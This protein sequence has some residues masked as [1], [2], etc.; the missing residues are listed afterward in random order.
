MQKPRKVSLPQD[1][2]VPILHDGAIAGPVAEGRL[3]PV[4]ILDT[5]KRSDIPELIRVHAHLQPG[6]A[7][8]EWAVSQDDSDQVILH[9]LFTRP[10]DVEMLLVFSIERQ[11]I[12]VETMLNASAVYLQAGSPEDSLTTFTEAPRVIVELPDMGFRTHWD[13]RLL[14]RM[15]TV[16]SQRLGT[17]RRKARP[18]AREAIADIRRLADLRIR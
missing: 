18:V 6:D 7:T 15:T 13:E 5:T 10:M 12:L 17:S 11:A 16:M 1:L 3:V 4:L 14:E 9:L 2:I 8:S